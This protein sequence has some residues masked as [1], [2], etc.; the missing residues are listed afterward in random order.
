MPVPLNDNGLTNIIRYL[1]EPNTPRNIR[2]QRA[3]NLDTMRRFGAPVILKHMYSDRDV[4]EGNAVPSPNFSSIYKQTRKGD[5]LSH[6][7]GFVGAENGVMITAPGEWVDSSGDLVLSPTSPGAGYIPAPKYRGYGPGYLT[8]VIM[9]DVS[10]DV[11]K[12]NEVGVLM[13]MQRAQAQM[14]WFPEVNDNDLLI[15]CQIGP[16]EQ[17]IETYERYLLKMTNPSS[18]RG[19]DRLG[20]RERS[21]DFGNRHVTDQ[22]FEMD[23]VPKHD[24]LYDVEV[25]R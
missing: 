8:Y 12:L 9:P 4:Q 24:E 7:I 1:G 19:I 23:L 25:D 14:G 3:S 21:E 5:P 11:F 15:T 10:E 2:Q 18:M 17:V 20:R 6:G 22:Q 13:R 16:Q